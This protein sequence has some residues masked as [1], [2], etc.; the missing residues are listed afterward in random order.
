MSE[1]SHPEN[2]PYTR[3]YEYARA[4]YDHYTARCR[5]AKQT[6]T[7]YCRGRREAYGG[8][9]QEKKVIEVLAVVLILLYTIIQGWQLWV[10]RDQ[11][12][13]QLRAY[14]GTDGL[15]FDCSIC[16]QLAGLPKGTPITEPV[17]DVIDDRKNYKLLL[18]IKN[19]GVTP[20]YDIIAYINFQ[21][22]PVMELLRDD[23]SYADKTPERPKSIIQYGMTT[24]IL[25]GGQEK[26]WR[27]PLSKNRII[28]IA[29]AARSDV[30]L[31]IYGHIDYTDIFN[32]RW[33]CRSHSNT[34]PLSGI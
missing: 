6:I 15:V 20:T 10:I 26:Q 2:A 5:T 7:R 8:W 13:R 22:V 21:T 9:E 28:E 11:E 17:T 25:G 19:F 27:Y 31:F 32:V 29:R 3:L 18:M 16:L 12:K 30:G 23:F 14:V 34:T 24:G 1:P 4:K 33:E